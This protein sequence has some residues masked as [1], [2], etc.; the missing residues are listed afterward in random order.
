M[1]K[2]IVLPLLLILFPFF[3]YSQSKIETEERIKK[4]EAPLPAQKFIDSLCFSS[5]IKWFVERNYKKKSYEAKTKSKK[6]KYSIEFDSWGNI[7]DI[8]LEIKWNKILPSTQDAICQKLNIDFEKFRIKKIQIQY[9]GTATDLLKVRT[10]TENLVSR[11]EIVLKGQKE[12]K[13]SFYEYLFSEKGELEEEV[14][15]DFRNT[16]HLEY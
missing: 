7:E 4:D 15:F 11:Y 14:E 12:G 5:K 6:G 9:T 13:S 2:K 3:C 1:M 16:D 8:E 10:S